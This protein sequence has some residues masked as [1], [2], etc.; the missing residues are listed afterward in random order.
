MTPPLRVLIIEDSE[1]D[2]FFLIRALKKEYDITYVRVDEEEALRKAL[3]LDRWDI[4]LS[5]YFM[6]QF[7]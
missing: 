5:D 3:S 4:V 2:C 6:P 7:D 1:D